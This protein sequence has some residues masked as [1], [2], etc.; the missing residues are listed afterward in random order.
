MRINLPDRARAILYIITAIGTPIMGVL[1]EQ[2]FLPGWA[3]T[4]WTAEVA[5][6]TAM[7]AFNVSV[8]NK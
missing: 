5:V 8:N 7:A 6:I 3:M 1:T 4:L 2:K